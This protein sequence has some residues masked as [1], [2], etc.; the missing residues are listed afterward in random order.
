ML[1]FFLWIYHFCL[2]IHWL[3]FVGY[4]S[5]F[6]YYKYFIICEFLSGDISIYIYLSIFGTYLGVEFL[7][8]MVTLFLTFWELLNCFPKQLPQF[9]FSPAMYDISSF[10]TYLPALLF[11]FF[12]ITFIVGMKLFPLMILTP[13]VIDN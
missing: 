11:I 3:L 12:I 5:T 7:G 1:H 6:T 13:S 9:T 8:N 2:S 4:F 10:F